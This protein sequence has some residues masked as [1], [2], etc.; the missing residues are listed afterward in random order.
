MTKFSVY[1]IYGFTGYVKLYNIFISCRTKC[2]RIVE[3]RSILSIYFTYLKPGWWVMTHHS[4]S[5]GWLVCGCIIM[6]FNYLLRKQGEFVE[7]E[8]EPGKPPKTNNK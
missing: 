4:I 7:K 1:N 5:I 2:V 3:M 6:I 8:I